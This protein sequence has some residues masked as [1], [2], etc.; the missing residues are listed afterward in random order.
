[1]G[2]SLGGLATF[3]GIA[4]PLAFLGTLGAGQGAVDAG[5]SY[6]NY[7]EQQSWNDYQKNLQQDIFAREDTSI[8]RRVNDLRAAGLSPV[9]A[10]G[11]GAQAGAVVQ[12]KAPQM[13]QIRNNAAE[14]MLQ[15]ISMKKQVEQTDAQVALL[16]QQT[17]NA[18]LQPAQILAEITKKNQ[19][20][21]NLRYEYDLANRS[22]TSI[23]SSGWPKMIKEAG[24]FF[25]NQNKNLSIEDFKNAKRSGVIPEWMLSNKAL[26]EVIRG[27]NKKKKN[28]GAGAN[29]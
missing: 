21:A 18:K 15:A 6:L 2:I 25:S 13:E 9:L 24:G 19:E 16:K 1:M 11:Q 12:T 8:Q 23:H 20:T 14:L 7:K 27:E 26:V 28:S 22:G 29:Y 10:A 4:N 5:I 3:L 17:E